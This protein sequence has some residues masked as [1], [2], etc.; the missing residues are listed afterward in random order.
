MVASFAPDAVRSVQVNVTS[1]DKVT[2]AY[3]RMAVQLGGIGILVPN[4]GIA[5]SAP[6]ACRGPAVP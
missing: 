4:A 3:A 1:E 5:S 2:D 6:F